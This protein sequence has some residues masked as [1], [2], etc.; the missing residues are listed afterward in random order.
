MNP[1][2]RLFLY[3]VA[4]FPNILGFLI[5]YNSGFQSKNLHNYYNMCLT[6]RNI[7]DFFKNSSCTNIEK[8]DQNMCLTPPQMRYRAETW[9]RLFFL[10][11]PLQVE[12]GLGARL[13]IPFIK[14]IRFTTEYIF[15][16]NKEIRTIFVS[17]T[18]TL[19][20]TYLYFLLSNFYK[21]MFHEALM[22]EMKV[23]LL[24]NAIFW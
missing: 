23:C 11:K 22:T 1:E 12:F 14:L 21:S 17:F 4:I 19:H 18:S 16:R 15:L 6:N 9:R 20:P 5:F 3:K 13:T 8:I 2:L 10:Y 24:G 7:S